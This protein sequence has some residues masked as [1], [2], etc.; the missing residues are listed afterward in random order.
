MTNLFASVWPFDIARIERFHW[1][2]WIT[3]VLANQVS[4]VRLGGFEELLI[5][6]LFLWL[7]TVHVVAASCGAG[8]SPDRVHD[9][10]RAIKPAGLELNCRSRGGRDDLSQVSLDDRQR[11]AECQRCR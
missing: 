7:A 9:R 6:T 1:S 5:A 10:A 3:C 4:R 8:P 2:A 11:R